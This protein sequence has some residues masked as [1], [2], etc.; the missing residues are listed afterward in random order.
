[1]LTRAT[2][3]TLS[4]TLWVSERDGGGGTTCIRGGGTTC[5]RGGGGT[6]CIRG[7]G[8]LRV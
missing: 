4:P 3:R 7:G 2:H 8:A 6:T 1:M 5:I